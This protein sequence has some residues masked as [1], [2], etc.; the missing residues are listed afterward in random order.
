MCWG[1]AL[2]SLPVN[3]V[4]GHREPETRGRS[5]SQAWTTAGNPGG[6]HLESVRLKIAS[7]L[8]GWLGSVLSGRACVGQRAAGSGPW[9]NCMSF[10]GESALVSSVG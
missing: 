2:L 3:W 7:E 8:G 10:S 5:R 1:H 9:L 4:S 6:R